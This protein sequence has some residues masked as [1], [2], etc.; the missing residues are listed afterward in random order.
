MQYRRCAEDIQR[1]LTDLE[2]KDRF[3][4][5]MAGLPKGWHSKIDWT[6]KEKKDDDKGHK[7]KRKHN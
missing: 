3:K 4:T 6:K 1:R 2:H 7:D 5:S